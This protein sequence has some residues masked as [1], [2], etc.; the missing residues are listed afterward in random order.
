MSSPLKSVTTD[1]YPVGIV[2][3]RNHAEN[4]ARTPSPRMAGFSRIHEPVD[5]LVGVQLRRARTETLRTILDHEL[6]LLIGAHESPEAG[7][8]MPHRLRA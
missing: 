1:S 8:Y 6:D 3:E 2:E 4:R 5:R 7:C